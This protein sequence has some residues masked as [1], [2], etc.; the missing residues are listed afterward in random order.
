M[1]DEYQKY[2]ALNKWFDRTC[3]IALKSEVKYRDFMN[4]LKVRF[5]V[6]LDWDKGMVVPND[7]NPDSDNDATF[8]KNSREF[9]S[10]RISIEILHMKMQFKVVVGNG[11]LTMMMYITRDKTVKLGVEVGYRVVKEVVC[12]VVEEIEVMLPMLERCMW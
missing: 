10:H 4:V 9:F 3:D 7:L 6:F 12:E 2:N 8:T 5:K 1:I 11:V